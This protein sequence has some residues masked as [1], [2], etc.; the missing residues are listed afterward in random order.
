MPSPRTIKL[1]FDYK[2]PYAYLAL[3]PAFALPEKFDIELRWIPYLLR[4][5]GKG[6]RSIYSEW[7]ARYSYMDARRWANRRGGFLIKGPQKV[8]DSTASL[9]GALFAQDHD[10][11]RAYSELVY[12][13]FFERKLEIDLTNEIAGVI[14]ELGHSGEAY[15]TFAKGEGPERFERCVDEGHEDHIFGVPIFLYDDEV[16]WGQDRMILLEER[17]T[18]N[19]L[20]R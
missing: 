10:F 3:E 12:T 16:F 13:R 5:K 11:F 19:G 4:I 9:I 20:R 18:E 8:Y 7:K 15:L 1:Y 17:L 2:S 6:Q 14:D